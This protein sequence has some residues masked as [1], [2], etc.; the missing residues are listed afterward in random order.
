MSKVP[1]T[2]CYGS[3]DRLNAQDCEYFGDHY[4]ECLICGGKIPPTTTFLAIAWK[5]NDHIDLH[6]QCAIE[7][8]VLLEDFM[9]EIEK[10]NDNPPLTGEKEK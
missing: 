3:E 9:E 1:F 5:D 7:L 8:G 6:L 4:G 2:Y 10:Q